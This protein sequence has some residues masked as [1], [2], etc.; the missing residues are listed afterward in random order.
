MR[1]EAVERRLVEWAAWFNAGGSSCDGGWPVKNILHPSWLPPSG[2]AS[3]S[4]PAG[5]R[6][7]TREREIH[8]AIGLLSD[9]SIAAVV[10][11]YC[12]RWTLVEQANALGCST[13]AL[14]GR[15]ARVHERLA[16]VLAE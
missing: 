10:V 12:K 2:G 9:R 4:L 8:R 5:R 16:V 15:I 1:V 14:T 7:D 13:A 3:R 6:A 11:H